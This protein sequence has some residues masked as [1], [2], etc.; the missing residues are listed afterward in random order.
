MRTYHLPVTIV[1][2]DGCLDQ[3]G[4]R[5][6]ALGRR[7][8]LVCGASARR[9]GAL[10]Q[11]LGHLSAAGL[12]AAVYEGVRGEPTL[13]VVAEGILLARQ[14][15]SDVLVGLGGGSAMDTAK[16]IAG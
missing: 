16:A 3:V 5:A 13:A 12:E 11:A 1:T 8:L 14:A 4:G 15:Q 9:S 6:A 7:V 2:G 10:D